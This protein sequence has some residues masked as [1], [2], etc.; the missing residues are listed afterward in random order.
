MLGYI[1]QFFRGQTLYLRKHR[2][3]SKTRAFIWT[4]DKDEALRM[5]TAKGVGVMKELRGFCRPAMVDRRGCVITTGGQPKT[6]AEL[7]A[8]LRQLRQDRSRWR[9]HRSS[10]IYLE[11]WQKRQAKKA[12]KAEFVLR[13]RKPPIRVT[14]QKKEH[15]QLDYYALAKKLDE[16]IE[17]ERELVLR[18]R[19]R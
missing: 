7:N 14:K 9:N 5:S 18:E 10:L 4:A 8:E 16:R 13:E 11:R 19:R 12:K 3:N 6:K 1:T 17:R 15:V 2:V